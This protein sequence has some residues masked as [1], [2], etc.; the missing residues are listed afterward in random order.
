[1]FFVKTASFFWPFLWNFLKFLPSI[2]VFCKKR[3]F[4][5]ILALNRFSTKVR[6]KTLFFWNLGVLCLL[7]INFNWDSLT[8]KNFV[9]RNT[10]KVIFLLIFDVFFILFFTKK[11]Q[12]VAFL[13]YA[14]RSSNSIFPSVV[15]RDGPNFGPIFDGFW[16]FWKFIFSISPVPVLFLK[17]NKKVKTGHTA[18]KFGGRPFYTFFAKTF[19]PSI[20]V[21]WHKNQ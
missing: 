11:R 16:D 19:L 21:F 10:I 13:G 18:S 15:A 6:K 12:K 1:M 5:Q 8:K 4:F 14:H 17:K 20:F 7:K 9:C 2:F 3:P